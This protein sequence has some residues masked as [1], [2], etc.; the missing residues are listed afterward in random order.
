MGKNVNTLWILNDI[1]E[2]CVYVCVV[3]AVCMVCVVCV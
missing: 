2:L 3:C 1:K